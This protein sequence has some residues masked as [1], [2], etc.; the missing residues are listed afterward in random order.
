MASYKIDFKPSVKRDMKS[1]PRREALIRLDAISNL[2]DNLFPLQSKTLTGGDGW[3]LRSCNYRVIYTVRSRDTELFVVKA[4]RIAKKS[5]DVF[6]KTKA[7]S[8]R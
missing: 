3:R 1:I 2:S 5:T 4:P 6:Y 7:I 8:P